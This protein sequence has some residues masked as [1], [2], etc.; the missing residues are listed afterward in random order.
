M[1]PT[2]APTEI[3]HG[4]TVVLAGGGLGNAVLFSIG[5]ALKENNNKVIYFAGYRAPTDL[6]NTGDETP[7]WSVEHIAMHRAGGTRSNVPATSS[8]RWGLWL[9][10]TGP[11]TIPLAQPRHHRHWLRSYDGGVKQAWPASCTNAP[12]NRLLQ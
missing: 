7:C 8:R 6:F 1:C 10:S 11:A 4:Q 3:P 2:G 5:L 9:R 12:A